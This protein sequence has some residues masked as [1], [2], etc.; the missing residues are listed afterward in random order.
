MKSKSDPFEQFKYNPDNV[1][2]QLKWIDQIS[3]TITEYGKSFQGKKGKEIG[4]IRT[5]VFLDILGRINFYLE[6]LVQLYKQFIDQQDMRVPINLLFRSCMGDVL[7]GLYFLHFSNDEK[8]FENELDVLDVDYAKFSK[9]IIENEAKI[10]KTVKEE[11]L[12]DFIQNKLNDYV[13]NNPR[14][15]NSETGWNL[16]SAAELR[17]DSK[18]ELFI[19]NS[20]KNGALTEKVK[21]DIISSNEHLKHLSI[22]Y[23]LYRYFSQY[24][25]YP[26]LVGELYMLKMNTIFISITHQL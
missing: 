24:Q 26:L 12:Y 13:K 6:G 18:P 5:F 20:H 10:T 21:F 4:G 14:I 17:N 9:F 11:E 2:L 15:F 3:R 23:L 22:T 1:N 16:K 19:D 25:H 8:S 7:N